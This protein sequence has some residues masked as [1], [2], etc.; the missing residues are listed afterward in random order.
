MGQQQILFLILG[1]CIG[2][3]VLS[4]S[5]IALQ[6]EANVNLRDVIVSEL[7]ELSSD[8]QEY[9]LRPFEKGGG[10]G[11][12]LGLTATPQG[13]AQLR[14]YR[15][16]L[17]AEYSITRSGNSTSVQILAIGHGPG[18]DPR[19]PIKILLTVFP[20]RSSISVLN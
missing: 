8:A 7:R 1:V 18:N 19:K 11:T 6:S 4:A 2:G 5:A 14:K 12:F 16:S 20:E 17:H 9:R 15:R 10:D 13:M 3:I